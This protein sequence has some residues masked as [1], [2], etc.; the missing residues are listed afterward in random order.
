MKT[1]SEVNIQ[2][3]AAV[4]RKIFI[5]FLTFFLVSGL[6]STLL[7]FLELNAPVLDWAARMLLMISFVLLALSWI[8][9]EVL[10][11]AGVPELGLAWLRGMNWISASG[12]SWIELSI[13]ERTSV[14]FAAFLLAIL[15][16]TTI[17]VWLL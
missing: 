13:G 17:S 10:M 8:T 5:S 16:V 9:P 7:V 3:F 6:I 15:A 12:K 4:S 14:Y 11:L 2:E 1:N